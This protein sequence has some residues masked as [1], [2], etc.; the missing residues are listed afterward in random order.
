[1]AT[2]KTTNSLEKLHDF[3]NSEFFFV[4]KMYEKKYEKVLRSYSMT[5]FYLIYLLKF[6]VRK[7]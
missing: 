3:S 4:N 2:S 6:Y 5:L 7:F 1:M